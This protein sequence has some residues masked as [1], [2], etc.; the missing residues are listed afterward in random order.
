MKRILCIQDLSA[1]GRTSLAVAAPVLSV[2]GCQCCPLP[3]ALL[4]T[5]MGGFDPIERLDTTDFF[6]GA[7]SAYRAQGIVFDAVC[8][9]Y[10]S[11]PRQ[12]AIAA[13]ELAASAGGLRVVDPAMADNG[14]LYGGFD[15]AMVAAMKTLAA[16]ADVLTP[17]AT[18]AALLAGEEPRARWEAA[19]AAA[20][21]DRLAQQYG[22][23]VVITGLPLADGGMICQGRGSAAWENFTLRCSYVDETYPGTGDLFCAVLVGALMR[24]NAL[25]SA[26]ELA[27]RFVEG[28]VKATYAQ[29]TDPRFG[30]EFEP[31]LSEL[32]PP[33]EEPRWER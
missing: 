4:S 30:V 31:R 27:L 21:C 23:R 13:A 15:G 3:A 18:E 11:S 28:A 9:G 8:T 26:A 10:L 25:Q 20:L 33:R 19:D 1:V 5:H 16:A 32:L 24:G 7:L 29:G 2:M 12:A 22:A 14:R 17:N 6:A